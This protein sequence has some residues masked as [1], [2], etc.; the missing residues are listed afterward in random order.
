MADAREM[1]AYLNLFRSGASSK[2]LAQ[3]GSRTS[4]LAQKGRFKMKKLLA[5]LRLFGLYGAIIATA[6]ARY[7]PRLPPAMVDERVFL[8]NQVF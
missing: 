2:A 8:A 3:F 4:Q 1:L 5:T 7:F 6:G